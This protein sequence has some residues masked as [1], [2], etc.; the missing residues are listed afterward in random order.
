MM[1]FPSGVHGVKPYRVRLRLSKMRAPA[2]DTRL[3]GEA[4]LRE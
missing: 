3:L 1:A 4:R 2:D